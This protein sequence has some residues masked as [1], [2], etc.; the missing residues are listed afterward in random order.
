MITKEKLKE[1]ACKLMFDMSDDEYQT[2]EAEF[3]FFVEQMKKIETLEHINQVP[4]MVFPFSNENASLRE[5]E[6]G[7]YLSVDEVL[8]NTKY[9]LND[10]VKVPKVVE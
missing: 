3:G 8:E 9:K 7:D 1:Y 4:P 6:I 10:Q 5:D 2:L